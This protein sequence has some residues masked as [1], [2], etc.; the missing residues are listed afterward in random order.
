MTDDFKP[1]DPPATD[2]QIKEL[3]RKLARAFI[4]IRDD[5]EDE[6]DRVYLG[7]SNDADLIR[8]LANVVDDLRYHGWEIYDD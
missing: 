6:G 7:S 1:L 8:D 3:A 5:L 2:A 4:A